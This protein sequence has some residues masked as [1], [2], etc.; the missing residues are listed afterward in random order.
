MSNVSLTSL[1][2]GNALYYNGTNWVNSAN[3]SSLVGISDTQTLTNKTLTSTTNTIAAN[4]LLSA[5]TTVNVG[6]AT[7]P[8]INQSLV[9]TSTTAATWQTVSHLNLSNIGTNTHV[10]IDTHISASSCAHGITG[11]VVGTSDTQTLT[12]KH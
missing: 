5:T 9:A 11:S 1:A 3:T 8:T 7:A 10:Q 6:S 4:N 12:K 2:S